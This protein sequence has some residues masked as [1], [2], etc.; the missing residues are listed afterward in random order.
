MA[1]HSKRSRRS[2]AVHGD[3]HGR[4]HQLA[5][6]PRRGLDRRRQPLLRRR[7]GAGRWHPGRAP[8]LDAR[9]RRRR[10][11][12]ARRPAAQ[13]RWRHRPRPLRRRARPTPRGRRRRARRLRAGAGPPGDRRGASR[14]SACAAGRRSSTSPAAAP[15]SSTSATT[16]TSEHQ[17]RI[18][19]ATV[20]HHVSIVPSSRVAE[21]V[22]ST[23]IGVNTLHHQAVDRLGDGLSAVAWSTDEPVDVIEA[24]ELDGRDVLGVQWHPELLPTAPEHQALFAWLVDTARDRSQPLP[25]GRS[26]PASP[27][28]PAPRRSLSLLGS[29]SV[30]AARTLRAAR[31]LHADPRR[32]GGAARH[33][34]G[35]RR[36]RHR[37]ADDDPRRDPAHDAR[38][39]DRPDLRRRLPPLR[40]QGPDARGDGPG[41][42]PRPRRARG[43]RRRRRRRLPGGVGRPR[44]EAG[45]GRAGLG[46]HGRGHDRARPP[47]LPSTPPATST[48]RCCSSSAAR[49]RTCAS[50]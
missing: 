1:T 6:G 45:A 17:D 43:H 41:R 5:R 50:S 21:V 20:I 42:A 7:R 10:A 40:P 3:R 48:P 15:S 47:T 23:Y 49:A 9:R 24:I 2:V 30:R 8:V 36:R 38:V 29:R 14:C 32:R 34:R 35:G 18:R 39:A 13:R 26:P 12:P 44:R 11:R 16:P 4:H 28:L 37:R 46:D 25:G 22:G 19:F 27:S 31:P 33:H